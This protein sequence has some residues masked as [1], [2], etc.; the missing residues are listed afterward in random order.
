MKRIIKDADNYR[1]QID[2]EM[3][4]A[5]KVN[6]LLCINKGQRILNRKGKYSTCFWEIKVSSWIERLV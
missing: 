4:Q 2:N 5:S 1:K 6:I 3:K